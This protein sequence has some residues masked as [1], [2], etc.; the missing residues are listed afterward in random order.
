MKDKLHPKYYLPWKDA[1]IHTHLKYT[2]QK[3]P[4]TNTFPN[5]KKSGYTEFSFV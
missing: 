4:A 5:N 1:K 2:K 3:Q